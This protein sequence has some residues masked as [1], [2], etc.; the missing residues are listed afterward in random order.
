MS[1]CSDGE[2]VG[3]ADVLLLHEMLEKGLAGGVVGEREVELLLCEG[4]Y[5]L[6]VHLPW[7][8]G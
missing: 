1:D 8:V 7:L 5:E 3:Q 6:L 2:V 4:F